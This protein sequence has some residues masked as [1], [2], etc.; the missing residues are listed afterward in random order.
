MI[1]A[2]S[3]NFFGSSFCDFCFFI[4]GWKFLEFLYFI[5]YFV[6]WYIGVYRLQF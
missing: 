3:A 4:V 6:I 5:I 1:V 2:E